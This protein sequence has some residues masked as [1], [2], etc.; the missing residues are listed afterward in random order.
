M[1]CDHKKFEYF[2]HE[3]KTLEETLKRN[4]GAIYGLMTRDYVSKQIN[5]KSPLRAYLIPIIGLVTSMKFHSTTSRQQHGHKSRR[6]NT[7]IAQ[8]SHGQLK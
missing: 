7:C 8:I 5:F 6:N 3:L 2:H 1:H 4:I